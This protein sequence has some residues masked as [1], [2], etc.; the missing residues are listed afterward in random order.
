MGDLSENAAYQ[1]AKD[2]L[3]RIHNRILSLRSRIANA[4]VIEHTAG[5]SGIIELGSRVTISRNGS[6]KKYEIVGSAE[7]KPANGRVSHQS[8]LGQALLGHRA[9]DEI[10]VTSP[11]QKIAYQIVTVD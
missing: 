1:Y 6:E 5:S 10:F 3:R 9:G 11:K 2:N 8:P 7:A 4:I